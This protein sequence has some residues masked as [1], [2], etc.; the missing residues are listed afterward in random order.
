MAREKVIVRRLEAIEN[1]G[2]MDVLCS[3]K[4]GTLTRG[5]ATVQAHVNAW[6]HDSPDVLRWAHINSALETGM[7]NAL[8]MAILEHELADIST[9]HKL[10]EGPA[11][12]SSAGS[13]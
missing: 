7:R 4:T 6:G 13:A 2:N 1:L 10:V 8:D 9:Y 5:I 3:D 11:T 12:T